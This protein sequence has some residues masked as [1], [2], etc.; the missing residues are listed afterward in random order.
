MAFEWQDVLLRDHSEWSGSP[1]SPKDMQVAMKVS[2][3]GKLKK[4][5]SILDRVRMIPMTEESL[6][7]VVWMSNLEDMRK[8]NEMW[9]SF[10]RHRRRR[11]GSTRWTSL[12]L[13]HNFFE[14]PIVTS[15]ALGYGGQCGATRR[16]LSR[17]RLRVSSGSKWTF[18]ITIFS[19]RLYVHN[20][21]SAF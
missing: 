10:P 9:Q 16:N 2:H 18:T 1:G 19:P 12:L 14:S 21:I 13:A 15:T 6:P 3:L 8:K 11:F 20:M 4:I 17:K 7:S 5:R